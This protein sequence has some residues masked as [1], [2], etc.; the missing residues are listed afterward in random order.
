MKSELHSRRVINLALIIFSCISAI[1]EAEE[2]S[3]NELSGLDANVVFWLSESRNDFCVPENNQNSTILSTFVAANCSVSTAS[4]LHIQ[5]EGKTCFLVCEGSRLDVA[6]CMIL[7]SLKMSP[8]VV[9]GGSIHSVN[10]TIGTLKPFAPIPRLFCSS[11]KNSERDGTDSITLR[12]SSFSSFELISIPFLA[13]NVCCDVKASRLLMANISVASDAQREMDLRAR[14]ETTIEGCSFFSVWDVIYGGIFRSVNSPCAS[15][16]AKNTSFECCFRTTNV[17]ESGGRNMQRWDLG[18]NETHVFVDCEW[19]STG[20]VGVGSAIYLKGNSTLECEV[21]SFKNLSHHH[22]GAVDVQSAA[23]VIM[24]GCNFTNCIAED[25]TGGMIIYQLNGDYYFSE[26]IFCDCK[27]IA[28]YAGGLRIQQFSGNGNET[29]KKCKFIRNEAGSYGGGFYLQAQMNML[30]ILECEFKG[31]QANGTGIQDLEGGGGGIFM[32]TSSWM[33]TVTSPIIM[34]HCFFSC[35]TAE[36]EEGHDVKVYNEFFKGSPFESSFSTTSAK[37]VFYNGSQTDYDAWL[38]TI[39]TTYARAD[40]TEGP[41]CGTT[42]TSPCNTIKQ[43]YNMIEKGVKGTV[44]ILRSNYSS[45]S[46]FIGGGD[47]SFKGKSESE[48]VISTELLNSNECLFTLDSGSMELSLVTIRHNSVE[49]LSSLFVMRTEAQMLKLKNVITSGAE[50]GQTHSFDVSPFKMIFEKLMMENC[51]I[52]DIGLEDCSLFEEEE[53]SEVGRGMLG[54][55]TIQRIC[56]MRGDGAIFSSESERSDLWEQES[57]TFRNCVCKEGNGG[58]VA[59]RVD[60]SETFKIGRGE[61]TTVIE[62]CGAENGSGDEKGRGGGIYLELSSPSIE[63]EIVNVRFE[64]NHAE[65]GVNVFIS[66]NQLELVP[67]GRYGFVSLLSEK[68]HEV[69]GVGDTNNATLAIP[70]VCYLMDVPR[71]EIYVSAS[72]A[73]HPRCGHTFFEC[74]TLN[75][76]I[77]REENTQADGTTTATIKVGNGVEV[78]STVVFS[79]M[80]RMIEGADVD[81]SLVIGGEAACKGEKEGCVGVF[82]VLK[83]TIMRNIGFAM[84]SALEH[85]EAIFHLK[86]ETLNLSEC[87]ITFGEEVNFVEY[88]LI[89]VECGEAN[90]TSLRLDSVR[91]GKPGIRANGGLS[92]VSL[93][94]VEL[95]DMTF[96]GETG[97]VVCEGGSTLTAESVIASGCEMGGSNLI[98]AGSNC[99]AR[100]R[101]CSW[102]SCNFVDSGIIKGVEAK[103]ISIWGCNGS[104]IRVREGNGGMVNGVVGEGGMMDLWNTS[105]E[106]CVAEKGNGGGMKVELK[107]DAQLKIRSETEVTLIKKCGAG[108]EGTMNGGGCGGGMWAGIEG[109]RYGFDLRGVRFEENRARSGKDVFVVCDDLRR[110][111]NGSSFSFSEGISERE[112]SLIGKDGQKFSCEVDLFIFIDG[113]SSSVINV[114][115]ENGDNGMWCGMENCPCRSVDYGVGRL[116]GEGEKKIVISGSTSIEKVGDVSGVRIEGK[117]N[118]RMKVVVEK[119]IEGE[120]ESVL[121]SNGVS[122]FVN[123]GFELP[124]RFEQKREAVI[125]SSTGNGVLEMELCSFGM[126]EGEE[127]AIEYRIIRSSGQTVRMKWISINNIRTRKC[128]MDLALLGMEQN[129]EESD[130]VSISNCSFGSLSVVGADE[131]AVICADVR[132]VM[133]IEVSNMSDITG[134]ESMNGGTVRVTIHDSGMIHVKEGTIERCAAEKVRGGKGGWLHVNCSERRGGMPFKFEGVKFAGNEAFVGKNMFIL[135][136]DLN[137]TARSETFVID[138]EGMEDD[139]N[140]FVGS[141]EKRI[142]TDLLRFVIEY[143]SERIVVWEKGD[144]VVRCGSEEDPCETLEMGLKHIERGGER[145]VVRVKEKIRVEGEYDLSGFEVES[146]GAGCDEMEYGTVVMGSE[147]ESGAKVC[148][149]NSGA[150]TL[151]ALEMCVMNVLGSGESGMIMSEGGKV[152]WED[153]SISWKGKKEGMGN[154]AFCVVKKG[155][156]KM[157]RFKVLSYFGKGYVFVVSGE[158]ASVIDELTVIETTLESGSL[159]E[160]EGEG[161]NGGGEMRMKNCSIGSVEGEGADPSVVSSKS[162]SGSG[163]TLVVED[164]LI[165]GC[166][167]GRSTKGGAMLFE[168]NEGGLFHVVNTSVK[169]CGCS[170]SE[171]KGGGVY[172][173]TE[174]RG[175]LDYVFD[176]VI[177]RR[178]TASVGNDVFIVCDCIERQINE[179]QF[180]ID[181]RDV[182]FIRQ[183][184]IYGMDAGEHKEEAM[185]LMSLIVKYQSDTIVVSS[186]EGK[187]GSNEQQC[188][189]PSLPC[190]TIGFGLRHLTHDFF[191]QVF[192]D[193]KSMI[194]EEIELETLTLSGMH[195]VQSRVVVKG[196]MNCSKEM[197]VE[198]NGQVYIRWIQFAFEEVESTPTALPTTHSSFM[199]ISSGKTSISMCSFE[200]VSSAGEEMVEVPFI[201][202]FVERGKCSMGNVSVMWLSFL[203]EAAMIMEEDT[204]VSGLTLK[205]IEANKDC[206]KISGAENLRMEKG[207]MG[208]A[209]GGESNKSNREESELSFSILSLSFD[210]ISYVDENVGL[211]DVEW[212][213][214]NVEFSNCSFS[215]CSSRRKKGKMMSLLMCKNI[216]MKLCLFDGETNEKQSNEEVDVCKWNGSVVEVKESSGEINDTSFVNCSNGGLSILGGSVEIEKGEFMN[217]NPLISNYPSLRRNIICSDSGTLN[218]MSLKG[219]DGLKDNTSLWILN[220]GCEMGGM[221]EERAS[222]LFIPVVEEARNET[223]SEGRTIITLSGRLLLPCNVSLKLSFRNGREEVVETYGI[224]EKE[225][226]S[227]NDIYAVVSSTHMGAA[228][229]ETEVSVSLLFGKIEFPSSTDSFILKNK[230]ELNVKGNERIVEGGKEGKSYLLL[231]VIILVAVLLVVLIISVIFI[232]RWR[233]QKRRAEELEAIVEDNIKKDPKL[234]EMMTMEMTPEEQWRRDEREAEKKNEEKIKKR[235]YDTNMEHSE[236]SEHLLSESGSTEYILGKDSDKIP[237][238]MLEKVD[239]KEEEEETRKRTPSPSIS[240]TLTTDSDSTFVRSE[241]LCP[242]TSSMSN[243][244]DA[245]ACS[246]PHEKLIVDLRDSL[247]MLLHGSNKTKEMAIGTLQER[248]QTAAQIL[249]WVAN[250][251]LHSFDEMENGLSSLSTLSPHIVLFSEHMVICI[252]MHSDFS[253]DDDSDSSSISSST[254]VKSASDGDDD[255]SDSLPSSAFEDED[256]N[257]NECLRWMAPELLMNRKMGATKKSVVFSIGMMLWECLTLEIPFGDYD[258]AVAGDKIV[259]GERPPLEKLPIELLRCVEACWN[260]ERK[261]RPILMEV[262]RALFER[263]PKDGAIFTVSDAITYLVNSNNDKQNSGEKDSWEAVVEINEVQNI[264]KK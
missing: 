19:C 128:L 230:T 58:D 206:M 199:K 102:S 71:S 105:I 140:L 148:L 196:R 216:Q 66:S 60:E 165:E 243:L 136:S 29:I 263:F 186:K 217:N 142:N 10:L 115:S 21:C 159:F 59:W 54:N 139:P 112:N 72:G 107:G 150:V 3:R 195:E 173:K 25:N 209:N 260:W 98:L 241:S 84:P 222:P 154:V 106:G 242:T 197:I 17:N 145:K 46:L 163:V 61:V 99:I 160:I 18:A 56:R 16:R 121:D 141:D 113:Y 239:E 187:G 95:N 158:V 48:C 203:S 118:K 100:M 122:V 191:S 170:V 73:D 220:E 200:G 108:I 52:E 231:I 41:I 211:V 36:N 188:G 119:G 244:V 12:D 252:V 74:R 6:G 40:G 94:N 86:G 26:C 152:E 255:E 232:V 250:L 219:G 57:T 117:D 43:A 38:P 9:D 120:G 127:E 205:N 144:D 124:D 212:I 161:A 11:F 37:R 78:G 130:S 223:A 22:D 82:V 224:G 238:W 201:L 135:D 189:K 169:Q 67:K 147:G 182:E 63:F 164:S 31:N 264:R 228:G 149:R 153:C 151:K 258:A 192:V 233:K 262:K 218:V 215:G 261:S 225:S 90:V 103:E 32:R 143:K 123:V 53:Q 131:S 23:G 257:R 69:E 110:V 116:G 33:D 28:H 76:P 64:N 132:K 214:A 156:L 198:T 175:E 8:F 176:R 190:A 167:C 227:E 44:N 162:G 193:E 171:G 111:V 134:G 24:S 101:E 129:I 13:P 4:V 133:K 247:F 246:S 202:I 155:E 125:S 146:V 20:N 79:K 166:S 55:V 256:D 207:W 85:H 88:S 204:E 194:D 77:E 114:E 47:I 126:Q 183:N 234:I 138:I 83:E 87:V 89:I 15:L 7:I 45:M 236:S 253:S 93:K 237:Q 30:N 251:A 221:M 27:A 210:N 70:I 177:F 14:T 254:V 240:S 248:E 68:A 259:N 35:N 62:D 39:Q 178:N 2:A 75:C 168:L 91:F 208:N 109:E 249:F 229:A 96:E 180:N 50:D 184:A 34:S 157:K 179:T 97:F 226:V 185:D 65:H 51:L 42:Q 1:C 80:A 92:S 81:G 174:L 5:Q 181:F 245:M 49:S 235:V 104:N 213:E 172:L 137:V